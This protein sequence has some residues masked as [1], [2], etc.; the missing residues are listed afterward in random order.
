M[1]AWSLATARAR[2]YLFAMTLVLIDEPG[3]FDDLATWARHLKVVQSLPDDTVL[4]AELI[5]SAVAQIEAKLVALSKPRLRQ[6]S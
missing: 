5:E 2:P 6:P 3:P 1:W 4:K